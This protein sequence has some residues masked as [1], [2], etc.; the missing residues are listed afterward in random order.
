M[1]IKLSSH[2]K[3]KRTQRIDDLTTQIAALELKHKSDPWDHQTNH[4]LSLRQELRTLLLHSYEFLQK[5]FKATS[6]STSNKAGKK[7]AQRLKGRR[8]KAK[9]SQLFHPHTKAPLSNP[10]DIANA[11]S[12][13]YGDLYNLKQDPLA[14]QPTPD[15][16]DQ[17][18]RKVKLPTLTTD[19]LKC[20]LHR[21]RNKNDNCLAT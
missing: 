18:L 13:Y 2:H 17:F 3:K 16:I 12:V 21:K 8:T 15:D 7:L 1:L 20:P 4:L 5:K 9:I 6:Y 11:F 19:R 10:Q 14:H